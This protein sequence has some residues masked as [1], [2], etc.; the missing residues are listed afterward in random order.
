MA[1]QIRVA[2]GDSWQ[3]KLLPHFA[4]AMVALMLITNVLNLKFVNVLGIS[5]IGSQV[6]YVFSLILADIMA[7]VYGYRRVRRILYMSLGCLIVYAVSVQIVVEMPPADG[8]PADREFRTVFEQSPRIALASV[9]AYFVT[10]LVNSF[11]MSGL[12]VRLSARYFYGR[13]TVAVGL[14]QIVNAATFFG[15]A[16]GGVMSLSAIVS[17]GAVSWAIVMLCELV[18][19]P[20]TKQVATR[21]KRYEGVEHFDSVPPRHP[22]DIASES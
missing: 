14:A 7:E 16:F 4:M 15:I 9:V 3:P 12:K 10:E 22:T 6:V 2:V 18:V 13:A 1:R 11:V 21:V 20:A 5:V 8:F 19:L 17:A